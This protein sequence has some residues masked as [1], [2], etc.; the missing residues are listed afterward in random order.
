MGISDE[1]FNLVI[2]SGNAAVQAAEQLV[3]EGHLFWNVIRS[4]F[5]YT[6]VLLAIDT[7]ASSVHIAAAFRGLENLV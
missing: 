4:V 5:Y 6:C 3:S 2:E 7:P 1:I